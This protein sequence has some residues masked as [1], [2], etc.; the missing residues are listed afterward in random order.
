VATPGGFFSAR[1]TVGAH[2]AVRSAVVET[3]TSKST[4]FPQ[5]ANK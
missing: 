2:I 3:A 5:F 1:H 4:T